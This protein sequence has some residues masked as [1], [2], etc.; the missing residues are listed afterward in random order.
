LA[1]KID[2][3]DQAHVTLQE[4]LL[5]N[6]KVSNVIS[7]FYHRLCKVLQQLNAGKNGKIL[8]Q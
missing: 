2:E 5:L 4:I 8:K 6:Q 3:F 1:P 7:H